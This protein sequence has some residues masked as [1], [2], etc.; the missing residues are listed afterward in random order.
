MNTNSPKLLFLLESS[1]FIFVK[2][3]KS[4]A[5]L[6]RI[7]SHSELLKNFLLNTLNYITI[8]YLSFFKFKIIVHDKNVTLTIQTL[9]LFL[10]TT[11]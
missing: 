8:F 7:S 11:I 9:V 3:N 1:N 4:M 5:F 2:K 10:G 6:G